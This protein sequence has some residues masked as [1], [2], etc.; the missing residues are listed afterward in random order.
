MQGL[1][2]GEGHPQSLLGEGKEGG[3]TG[4]WGS[5]DMEEF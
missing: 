1:G 5:Q 3:Q 2:D 4:A